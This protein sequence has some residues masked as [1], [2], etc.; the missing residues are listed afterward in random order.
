M[1]LDPVRRS[2]G[3]DDDGGCWE[4]TPT[5]QRRR[6]DHG[7]ARARVRARAALEAAR[8]RVLGAPRRERT[9]PRPARPARPLRAPTTSSPSRASWWGRGRGT[10]SRTPRAHPPARR[11]RRSA[12]GGVRRGWVARGRRRSPRCSMSLRRLPPCRCDPHPIVGQR[13]CPPLRPSA[14]PPWSARR[15]ARK[16]AAPLRRGPPTRRWRRARAASL[17]PPAR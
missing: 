6:L 12:S 3:G 11:A 7:P 1:R 15:R 13:P 16:R 5:K 2:R 4:R 9:A 14:A 17:S 8:R 10:R